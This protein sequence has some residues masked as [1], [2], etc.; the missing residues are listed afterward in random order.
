MR[1]TFSDTSLSLYPW[2]INGVSREGYAPIA[3]YRPEDGAFAGRALP[4]FIGFPDS[5]AIGSKK[6]IFKHINNDAKIIIIN[7]DECWSN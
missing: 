5:R 1:A 4:V 7:R 2:Q 3:S 6:S